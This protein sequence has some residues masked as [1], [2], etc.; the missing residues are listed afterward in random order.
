MVIILANLKGELHP[1]PF[2]KYMLWKASS[3]RA[4]SSSRCLNLSSTFF[5]SWI[6]SGEWQT[7]CDQQKIFSMYHQQQYPTS[8]ESRRWRVIH[9]KSKLM[10]QGQRDRPHWSKCTARNKFVPQGPKDRLHQKQSTVKIN[11][12]QGQKQRLHHKESTAK[13]QRGNPGHWKTKG[14]NQHLQQKPQIKYSNKVQP[15]VKEGRIKN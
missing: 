5:W 6:S 3:K 12:P 1:G 10:P 2:L 8:P 15:I 14:K 7:F 9:C 11:L 4:L 13:I